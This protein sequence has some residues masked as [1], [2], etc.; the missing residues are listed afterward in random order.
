[1]TPL[2]Y[3]IVNLTHENSVAFLPGPQ[4]GSGVVGSVQKDDHGEMVGAIPSH[5]SSS[6]HILIIVCSGISIYSILDAVW[7]AV[8][9]TRGAWI[10]Q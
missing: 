6:A 1:M 10:L 7:S 2:R 8:L 5:V 9:V 3:I 4:N